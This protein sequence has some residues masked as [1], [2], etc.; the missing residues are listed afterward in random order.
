MVHLSLTPLAPLAPPYATINSHCS[1]HSPATFLTEAYSQQP[2]PG[3]S[4]NIQ[5][6][7]SRKTGCY[8]IRERKQTQLLQYTTVCTLFV[9]NIA[10]PKINIL[11]EPRSHV[12]MLPPLY[13]ATILSNYFIAGFSG[14][15][16]PP[17]QDKGNSAFRAL[18][19]NA[20]NNP[21]RAAF[22]QSLWKT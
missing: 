15:R 12:G 3:R 17:K 8:W 19:R 2:T 20:R 16:F 14:T 9:R 18:F 13:R 22:P 4:H 21:V 6:E 5:T 10:F 7:S 11:F 1:T